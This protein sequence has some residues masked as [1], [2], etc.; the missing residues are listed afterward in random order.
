M[1]AGGTDV[2]SRS[3][4]EVHSPASAEE[5]GAGAGTG[6]GGARTLYTASGVGRT[7]PTMNRATFY[8][9]TGGV[10]APRY[11]AARS[12]FTMTL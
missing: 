6:A 10:G 4:T 3:R 8:Q 12:R 2:L 11:V 5:L 1:R 9:L 7:S